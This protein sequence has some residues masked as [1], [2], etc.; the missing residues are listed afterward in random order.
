MAQQDRKL[1]V[2]NLAFP[3]AKP[4]EAFEGGGGV[5]YA[6]RCC[7]L[8]ASDDLKFDLIS[9]KCYLVQIQTRASH[10]TI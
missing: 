8:T 6:H 2:Q 3:P 5:A 4:W 10:V 7:L 1:G 9:H